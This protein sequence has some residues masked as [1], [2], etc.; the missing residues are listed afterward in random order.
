MRRV[1][2]PVGVRVASPP[3]PAVVAVVEARAAGKD[4]SSR[5][6]VAVLC[7]VA[8][9]PE[10]RCPPASAVVTTVAAEAPAGEAETP[11]QAGAVV[12]A[13]AEVLAAGVAKAVVN[14]SGTST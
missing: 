11:T 13:A 10:A 3:S 14:P 2:N 12:P 1:I 5:V 4:P 6:A 9:G 8:K 7:K